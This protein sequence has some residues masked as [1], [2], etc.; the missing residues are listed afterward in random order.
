[1]ESVTHTQVTLRLFLIAFEIEVNGH[2]LLIVVPRYVSE[3]SIN[4]QQVYMKLLGVLL[5]VNN[6]YVKLAQKCNIADFI[7][8][9]MKMGAV[10]MVD[11]WFFFCVLCVYV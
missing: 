5:V 7:S 3:I 10:H 8:K 9:L 4:L 1:M 2:A 11:L 6:G